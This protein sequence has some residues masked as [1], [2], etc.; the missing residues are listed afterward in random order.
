VRLSGALGAGDTLSS[1]DHVCWV[2][3]DPVS[4]TDAAERFLAEGLAR[5]ERLMCV[6]NGL[7]EDLRAAGEPFGS[8]ADL[9]A[10]GALSFVPVTGTY[11]DGRVVRAEEQL[12]YYDA[13]V[14]AARAEGYRGLRVVADVTPLAGTEAGRA[15][16][17]RWEHVADEYIA[18][19]AGM[20]ALCAYRC[21]D[22]PPEAVADVA[23]VHPQ[24][25]APHDAP[26]FRL[27][28]DGPR[29]ALAGT[30]DTFAADRLA[31]VL[32]GISATG[33]RVALDLSAVEVVD[34][35]GARALA[36]WAGA[37]TDRGTAVHLPG[38]PTSLVRIWSLL[39]LGQ[40]APV[41]FAEPA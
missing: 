27:W 28:F 23:S 2:Y 13:A 35:A 5:G 38:A 16:L 22:L 10:R 37:L 17:V 9:V 12:A 32:A 25:H 31:R 29:A 39:G 18:S 24:V 7:A 8:L 33:P 6:G 3:D 19:G 40:R 1:A 15:G 30:V 4:F 41:E 21:R 11:A 36:R 20:V 26:S 14:Q 34:A